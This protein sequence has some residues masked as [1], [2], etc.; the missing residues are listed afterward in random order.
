MR[1]ALIVLAALLVAAPAARAEGCSADTP[2]ASL[3]CCE[4]KGQAD[5]Q[6][7]YCLDSYP[8][9]YGSN[10]TVSADPAACCTNAAA[11]SIDDASC[12]D[13][14]SCS[15]LAPG[16]GTES[17]NCCI[18]KLANEVQD[19]WCKES[20][21]DLYGSATGAPDPQF[22]AIV[23]SPFG[24]CGGS[25]IA[26]GYVLT[27]AQCVFDGGA[28]ADSSE[29]KVWVDGR[30]HK[31]ETVLVN[32]GDAPYN[33]FSNPKTEGSGNVAMLALVRD[34]AAPCA[35]LPTSDVP[36]L[37]AWVNTWAKELPATPA[38]T[39]MIPVWD[40]CTEAG[41]ADEFCAGGSGFLQT[42]PD[43]KG[44]PVMTDSSLQVGLTSGPN[45]NGMSEGW[46]YY[47]KLADKTILR[48]ITVWLN[49]REGTDQS[50]LDDGVRSWLIEANTYLDS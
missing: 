47:L 48:Q 44:S 35:T 3:A 15:V 30:W 18:D 17:E 19:D 42:C 22:F 40:G 28:A 16:N 38:V 2:E 14:L 36:A 50:G 49:S 25:L 26:P 20:F 6:D 13:L 7:Q 23:R 46:G 24:P 1:C 31:V 9:V 45:C 11:A 34:S 21:P 33:E 41:W 29:V 5:E 32:T 10:C 39:A 4:T 8:S 43:D 37:G 12:D 27:A